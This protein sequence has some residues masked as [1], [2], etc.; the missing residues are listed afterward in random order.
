MHPD[1]G[2]LEALLDGELEPLV[3]AEV[4]AH[5]DACAE[6]R[7]L[8][9]ALRAD[10]LLANSAFASLDHAGPAIPIDTVIRRARAQR[11]TRA[12]RWAAALGVLM[13]GA[14]SLYAIPGSPV[15][16]WIDRLLGHRSAPS[17]RTEPAAA[18]IAVAPGERFRIAFDKFPA[19]SVTIRL[20]ES[21]TVDARRTTGAGTA[22]FSAEIDGVRIVTDTSPA[23]FAIAIP[24]SAPWV[25]VL[26]GDRRIFLKDGSRIV[27]SVAADAHGDYIIRP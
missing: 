5:L 13:L 23:D 12:L 22:R 6:C 15:R 10:G 2:R 21:T 3:V 26:A 11:S 24:R 25:E 20:T 8:L 19:G 16:Q 27:T 14:G 1:E 9:A 7:D 18:G 4:N 17:G